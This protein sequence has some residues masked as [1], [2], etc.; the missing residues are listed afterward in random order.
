METADICA[1]ILGTHIIIIILSLKDEIFVSKSGILSLPI[2]IP[3][4]ID[5]YQAVGLNRLFFRDIKWGLTG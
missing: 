3:T 2:L 5:P 4:N 1:L